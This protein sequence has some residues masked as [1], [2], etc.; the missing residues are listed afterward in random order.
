MGHVYEDSRDEFLGK[1]ELELFSHLPEEHRDGLKTFLKPFFSITTPDELVAY[2][3]RD[4]LGSTLAFWRFFQTHDHNAPK[5]EV[6]NPDY[7]NNG[8]H[9]THTIIQIVHPDMPFIVDS[10]R[11][12]LNERGATIHHLRNCVLSVSRDDSNTFTTRDSNN[13]R[14]AL[15]YIEVNRLG[16]DSELEALQQDLKDVLA[17]VRRVV[18]DYRPIARKVEELVSA[19]EQGAS[20][21]DSEVKEVVDYLRWLLDDNFTFLAYEELAVDRSQEH[22]GVVPVEGQR[23]GLLRP[24]H[25]GQLDRG[26]LEPEMDRNILEDHSLLSFATAAARSSV[27]RPAYPNFILVKRFD[28]D[29]NVIGECRIMG[30]YTSPVYTQSPREIP[31]LRNKVN[32][33]IKLAGLNMGGHHGKE[34]VQT[35]EVFP[36]E[37]LFLTPADQLFKTL[38]G[39]LQIQERHQIRVFMRRD[40]NDLFCSVLVYVPREVYDTTLRKQIQHI[41]CKRLNAVDAEFTTHFSESIL[42]RVHYV[43][44]LSEHALDDFNPKVITAE[45]HQAA[46]SWEDEFRDSILETRGE[47][48]GHALLKSFDGGFPVSYRD[49]FTPL[50][51]V[52]DVD[53]IQHLSDES[54]IAMS[55]YQPIK[56]DGYLH[57]KVFHCG[58]SLPLSDL[59]PIMENLGLRVI[60]EHPYFLY[61]TVNGKRKRVSL[62]DFTLSLTH[63]QHLPLRKVAGKFQEAFRHTWDGEAENDR[64]NH[65]V[66]V[67]GMDWRQVSMFRAYA[68]YIKQIRFGFSQEYIADTLCNNSNIALLLLKL[69]EVSFD[70]ELDLTQEQRNA[71]RQQYQQSIFEALDEV[72][73]LSEDRILRRF[74]DTIIAT[75]RTNFYQLDAQG[76]HHDYMS[77]KFSPGEIP[78]IPRP[79]PLFEIFVY[80]PAVEGVHLRGGKV[81][82]GGLRWSDRVEDYRTEVL[83]LVKA[84]QVK[85]AV[86]VPVGAKGGFVPK[87]LPVNGTREEIQAE[88]I[89]CYKRFIKGLLDVT[90]NL[91]DNEV[92]HPKGVIRYDEDDTYLVVAADKG[93]ATFSDIANSIAEGYGFWLGDAFASGGS[94]GY[95][96]KKMGITAKGAWV[97]VQRH[98]RERGI[99]VQKDPVTVVGIGDMAGD[100]FGNGLLSSRALKLVAAFNHMHIFVDPDPDPETS[101]VERERLFALPRSS[102]EDYDGELISEGGG[103]FSRSAKAVTISP[104]M[105]KAFG[106]RANRLTPNDLISAILKA[107][108]DLI[109]NGGIGTY[110]KSSSESHA[111][112]GDKAND[113]L[114]IDGSQVRA[115]VLGEGGNLGFTQLGRIQFALNG[116]A[117][118]T[119]FIDNAGGVDCSDHEV[120]I[121]ILLNQIE[122]TGDM[123]RKQRDRMLENMTEEVSTLVLANNYRQTQAITMAEAECLSQMEEYKGFIHD[124]EGSGRLD[125]AI[126]FLPDD[127]TIRERQAAG[128][129]LTRPEL[130]VL[131]SYSKADLKEKLLESSIPDDPY[132]AREL[133]TA[134]P[135]ALVKKYGKPL[136]EHRLHREI[137]STQIANYLINMMGITFVSRQQKSTGADAADIVAGFVVARDIFGAEQLW[138]D[139]ESLD[140]VVRSE[141]QH[142][143]MG[144]VMRLLRRATRWL[145]R[146]RQVDRDAADCVE[147]YQS[148]LQK[149]IENLSELLPER[150]RKEWQTRVDQLVA[151]NVP[152]YLAQRIAGVRHLFSML[153]VIQAVDQTGEKLEK[154]ASAFFAVGEHLDLHWFYQELSQL[155]VQNHWQGLAREG[156]RDELAL[157]QRALTVSMLQL[158]PTAEDVCELLQRWS[159][160]N[161]TGLAR[162]QAILEEL[163][164]AA[165]S[166]LA[167]YTVATRE[168]LDLA[169]KS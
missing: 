167:M 122:A 26:T 106:I 72:S 163:R 132:L 16:Q 104:Q 64:F 45:I 91:V 61:R 10:I 11:M 86:I 147:H 169:Q 137:V 115:S 47:V 25:S 88:G 6:L 73:V 63:G 28:K 80:S 82:R 166:E 127:E 46:Y 8:W 18:T 34:L 68:R 158:D 135:K 146:M 113:T 22:P 125:R 143:L 1:L 108:V 78:D 3:R 58:D 32:H 162:W 7:E 134:F 156:V 15:L 168:L 145:V 140:H 77:F 49:A 99:D 165:G 57:F 59:I 139:I 138:A 159:E 60:G 116:G 2:R 56:D 102:W 41:L 81:A 117:L 87:R 136:A 67:A 119:D 23:L 130:S 31:W 12:K 43:L 90:D 107:K 153:S 121:K 123:T 93:T 9:S 111:D 129:G 79:A 38:M 89:A 103:I 152:E 66:L 118:N 101:F 114:R 50:T 105:K 161:A 164:G 44:R 74:M 92:V 75:L 4:L 131:I 100:V 30:L 62:H 96:H 144:E 150:Q 94:A 36:R 70:P 54:P 97:S 126:E 124:L 154:V 51:A 55:F 95:D 33:I 24:R 98:F 52:A 20:T 141:L 133:V 27:H 14:E 151:R 128:Q 40:P 85:N 53:H 112:V 160:A 5:V 48:D 37:E 71:R 148:R 29:G 84:Q 76:T 35:I 149:M 13:R 110:V 39:I 69:F 109:W 120:N 42:A 65:L 83:G 142:E 19:L 157:Q 17:D 21:K 155:E